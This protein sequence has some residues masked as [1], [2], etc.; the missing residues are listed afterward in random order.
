MGIASLHPSC[1]CINILSGFPVFTMSNTRTATLV[2][3]AVAINLLTGCTHMSTSPP[4]EAGRFAAIDTAIEAFI[5][6]RQMPGAVFWLERN[7]ASYQKA[8]GRHTFE[9]GAEAMTLDSVF[10]AA[11]LTKV[12]ATA[13]SVMLLVEDGK[14]ALDAPLIQYFPECAGG[15]KEAIS[16]RHLLTHTSGL[17]A[18]LPA[19]PPWRGEEAALKLACEQI[20]THLPGSFFRY[21]DI[22]FVLLGLLVKRISGQPLNEFAAQRLFGPLKMH[23]TGF[24]PRARRPATELSHIAPTQKMLDRPAQA[25]HGDLADGEV[26]RGV[27]HDP[28]I[29]FMGGVGGSA[30]VFTTAGDVARFARMMLNDGE[31]EGV[32][33][34]SRESVRL[35]STVQSPPGIETRRSAGWDIESPYSRPRGSVFPIGSY[36]HTGFTGCIL[37]IDPFSKTFYVLLSNRVYPDDK[38]SILEL[39]SKLGTLVARAVAGFDFRQVPGTPGP[40]TPPHSPSAATPPKS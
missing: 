15:G 4:L 2:S 11:S 25:L 8:Y 23:H 22:N 32:R 31:L 9:S 12:M 36:G 39:Y 24:V 1:A 28:T 13:P 27:V 37:W 35:M 21:S 34:L 7:G 5:A 20:V 29:R 26:L 10:D 3:F 18:G 19:T 33:G 17:A 30:G 40:R 38:A 14:L 16:V 6:R